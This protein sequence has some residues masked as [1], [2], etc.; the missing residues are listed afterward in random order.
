MI[1][2]ELKFDVKKADVFGNKARVV[3]DNPSTRRIDKFKIRISGDKGSEI[4]DTNLGLNSFEAK[5]FDIGFDKNKVGNVES[6]ET[7]PVITIDGENITF[8]ELSSKIKSYNNITISNS[9][10]KENL[11]LYYNF[12]EEGSVVK[13]LS[14]NGREGTINGA[15]WSTDSISGNSLSFD[16]VNDYVTIPNLDLSYKPKELT[17]S[18]WVKDDPATQGQTFFY[19]GSQYIDGFIYIRRNTGAIGFQYATGTTRGEVF[20]LNFFPSQRIGEPIIP[21]VWK[22]VVIVADYEKDIIKIYKDGTIFSTSDMQNSIP[23]HRN[24]LYIGGTIGTTSN[25]KGN[26]DEV[27]VWDKI[28]TEAEIIDIYNATK[29]L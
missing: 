19:E 5:K 4:I 6:I 12:D 8:S 7:F 2:S 22:H 27:T 17:F 21:A 25:L 24:K 18:F 9:L 28:L 1:A 10:F 20:L 14:D 3:I 13:D 23:P 11:I 29:P 26:I 15:T 16:G